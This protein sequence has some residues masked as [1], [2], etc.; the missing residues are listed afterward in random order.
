MNPNMIPFYIYLVIGFIIEMFV[1]IDLHFKPFIPNNEITEQWY[2][3]VFAIYLLW[4]ICLVLIIRDK[5]KKAEVDP[6]S[7]THDAVEEMVSTLCNELDFLWKWDISN[8]A[9]LKHKS[10][11]IEIYDTTSE[12][13]R[14]YCK[15][16]K[17]TRRQKER[18]YKK[19]EYLRKE[20]E[21]RQLKTTPE[22][23]AREIT[24]KLN[25][26]DL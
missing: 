5:Y 14:I 25:S 18:L 15:D 7:N 26:A 6:N 20:V 4:P 3:N 22:Q 10:T 21:A 16:I 24:K 1:I 2:R 13:I 23:Q 9:I 12:N 11:G 17:L 8:K 19:C